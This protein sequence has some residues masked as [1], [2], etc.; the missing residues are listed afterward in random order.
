MSNVNDMTHET[1]LIGTGVGTEGQRD[2]AIGNTS[3]PSVRSAARADRDRS[4]RDREARAEEIKGAEND[5]L[6]ARKRVD[7][8]RSR[9]ADAKLSDEER[10]L[11]DAEREADD[12]M[13]RVAGLRSGAPSER[14]PAVAGDVR[15]HPVAA[16][17][18]DMDLGDHRAQ[19]FGNI[20]ANPKPALGEH[21]DPEKMTNRMVL[22]TPD[23]LVVQETWVH[24]AMIG[25]YARAGWELDHAASAAASA[26]QA[27]NAAPPASSRR[28]MAEE[29]TGPEE[30]AATDREQGER[31]ADARPEAG[32]P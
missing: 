31:E 23:S 9:I 8:L 19:R 1:T 20:P 11:R 6:E 13:A 17:E 7:D 15:A 24:S 21:I 32:A 16:V 30:S 5:A 3:G 22:R 25:D 27:A 29:T 12:A 4:D 18:P 10:E 2:A 28:D 26:R 14:N